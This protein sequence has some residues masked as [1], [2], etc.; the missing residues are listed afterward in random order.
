MKITIV[1]T[2]YVGLSLATLMAQFHE[3]VSLDIDDVRI[4]N[5]NKRISPINDA[6]IIEFFKN[7]NLSL[8]ATR[9]KKLAYKDTNL[10]IVCT[11]TNYD[12]ETNE[13][14]TSTVESVINDSNIYNSNCPIII[15]S[16]VPVGFTKKINDKLNSKNIVFSPEFLRE[17][18]ALFDNLNPDRIIVGDKTN[19]GKSFSNLMLDQFLNFSLFFSN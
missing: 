15:K 10:V 9:N 19:L 8:L 16:T 3:V 11:P 18:K 12:I 5:I 7:K 4:D 17:G 2:G 13:F 14:D 1:G 6:D